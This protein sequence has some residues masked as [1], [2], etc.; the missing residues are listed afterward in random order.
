MRSPMKAA[1]GEDGSELRGSHSSRRGAGRV[2]FTAR[3]N[4]P[5]TAPTLATAAARQ[6]GC[7]GMLA[8]GVYKHRKPSMPVGRVASLSWRARGRAQMAEALGVPL[9]SAALNARGAGVP[10]YPR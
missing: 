4:L 10:V 9:M 7:G 3:L 6:A 8:R 1:G 2:G 5:R